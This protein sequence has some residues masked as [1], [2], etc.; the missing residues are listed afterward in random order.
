MRRD[1]YFP[2]AL[3][4]TSGRRSANRPTSVHKLRPGDIQVIASM[5]DSLSAG[6]GA[7][8]RSEFTLLVENRGVAWSG[9]KDTHF[10]RNVR[11]GRP[12]LT[13]LF[14][15]RRPGQLERIHHASQH[16]KKFQPQNLWLF[17]S[18]CFIQA[19][20]EYR[21]SQCCR[22]R[23]HFWRSTWSGETA[24][25]ANEA[26]LS[27]ELH[28]RLE[29]GDHHDWRQRWVLSCLR[30]PIEEADGCV[31]LGLYQEHS[32]DARHLAKTYA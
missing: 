15:L 25:S 9:G 22:F 28:P 31:P 26:R 32:K 29:N 2:C 27:R 11:C 4:H 5:G 19:G 21:C 6:L 7:L 24:S 30:G 23:R 17:H 18:Q 13:C 10:C 14:S 20:K 8:A 12:A 16:T 1:A 3:A